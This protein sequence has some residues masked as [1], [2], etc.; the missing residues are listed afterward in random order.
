[1][2][3]G[4]AR[5]GNVGNTRSCVMRSGPGLSY[6][7]NVY[8]FG[9]Y[10]IS[11]RGVFFT[12]GTNVSGGQANVVPDHRSMIKIRLTSPASSRIKANLKVGLV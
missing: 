7:K 3:E 12:N 6:S 2:A 8:C 9:N 10:K 5:R 11:K 4:I 1:M